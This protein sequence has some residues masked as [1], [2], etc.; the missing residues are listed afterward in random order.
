M[1]GDATCT[2]VLACSLYETNQV[3]IISTVAGNF[4]W[5]PIKKKFYSKIE[6]NTVDMTFHHLN[7]I[8]MYNFGMVSIDIADKLRMKYRPDHWMCNRK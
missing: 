6:N 1:K 7:L 4:K 2:H 5:T 3:K 8:Y